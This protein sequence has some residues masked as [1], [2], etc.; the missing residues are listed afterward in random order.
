MIWYLHWLSFRFQLLV[1]LGLVVCATAAFAFRLA[2]GING[3][4]VP[5]SGVP[6][7]HAEILWI[8]SL[9]SALMLAGNGLR[10]RYA[11]SYTLALPVS[12][13][14]IL[15]TRF[16]LGAAGLAAFHLL[17]TLAAAAILTYRGLAIP[18]LSL[19]KVSALGWLVAVCVNAISALLW[20]VTSSA[21]APMWGIMLVYWGA[22]ALSLRYMLFGEQA[23]PSLWFGLAAL[24]IALLAT[25]SLIAQRRSFDR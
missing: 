14:G 13:L 23:P 16:T 5:A 3:Y 25:T 17:F 8:V 12:R 2:G 15:F 24:T 21:V 19:A 11:S 9:T 4:P 1:A 6:S 7:A 10:G 18:W 20:M 22:S